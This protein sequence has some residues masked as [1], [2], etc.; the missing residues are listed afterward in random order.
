MGKNLKLLAFALWGLCTIAA[1]QTAKEDYDVVKIDTTLHRAYRPGQVLVKFKDSSALKVRSKASGKVSANQQNV[2]SLM[3]KFGV[4]EMEQLM[5]K[6]G[7]V[8]MGASARLRSVTGNILEDRDLTKL[9]LLKLD[10][11]HPIQEAVD[12]FKQLEEVEF[13]E[14]NYLVYALGTPAPLPQPAPY[15]YI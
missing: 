1:A 15:L 12:A 10:K 5:P 7:A 11:K 8:K 2:Q 13:A 6:S 3:D 4:S 14:P 9:Y